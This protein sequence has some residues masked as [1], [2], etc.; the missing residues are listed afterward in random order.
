MGDMITAQKPAVDAELQ[1]VNEQLYGRSVEL[2]IRNQTLAILSKLYEIINTS[3][4]VSDTAAKL[5]DAIVQELKFTAGFIGL[6]DEEKKVLK[7]IGSAFTYSPG[8][9]ATNVLSA[10]FN[11]FT[12]NL[13]NQDNFCTLAIA[14]NK[15]RMTNALYDIF[16]PLIDK[17]T[18]Q[19]LQQIAEIKT[20]MLY[21]IAFAGRPFGLLMIGMNKH[22]GLLSRAEHETLKEV[23]KVVGIAVERSQIYANLKIVN[24]RLKELDILKDEFVS[25][26]SHELRTPMTAIKSYLWLS[27]YGKEQISDKLRYYLIRSYN[28][29]NRLIKL[30]NDMLNVSRIESGRMSLE[31]KKIKID[32][33]VNEVVEEVN[34][35]ANELGV[36]ITMGEYK[37]LPLVITDEDKIKEVIINLIGNSLKFTQKGGSIII[38]FTVKTDTV[39][40]TIKDTGEGI[41]QA[42]IS[43][44][45]KKFGFVKGSYATNQKASLGTG[46]G[47]YISKSIIEMHGGVMSVFSEGKGKGATFTFSLKIYNEKAL[48]E[49]QDM[50]KGKEGLGI[51]H[52]GL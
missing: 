7:V 45:F 35:R 33:L 1:K 51:I 12:I 4:G 27:L 6:I 36:T 8:V 11:N 43:K 16:I 39:M 48:R 2:A 18:S 28:A 22:V 30:V 19:R 20:T 10:A 47:L 15:A 50:Q 29:A 31:V 42:D 52:S 37:D 14:H 44:L 26:A 3:L 49:I 17:K 40:V 5:I 24:I 41:E 46:L 38:S 21:P 25:I 13:D 34:F 9:H 32:Q 23:I